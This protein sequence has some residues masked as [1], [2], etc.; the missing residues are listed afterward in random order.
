MSGAGNGKDGRSWVGTKA[1]HGSGLNE[2]GETK[3]HRSFQ[4]EGRNAKQS[5]TTLKEKV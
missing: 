3:R 2:S 1:P 5:T 4:F